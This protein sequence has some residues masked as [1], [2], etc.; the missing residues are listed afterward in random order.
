MS[1]DRE[2]FRLLGRS[3]E[4]F[5]DFGEQI[6]VGDGVEGDGLGEPGFVRQ[7]AF[8]DVKAFANVADEFFRLC[9]GGI[10]DFEFAAQRGRLDESMLAFEGVDLVLEQ[11]FLRPHLIQPIACCGQRSLTGFEEALPASEVF[12]PVLGHLVGPLV[13]ERIP[14][15]EGI[16]PTATDDQLKAFGAAA[17]SSGAVALFHAVGVTPEAATREQAFAGGEPEETRDVSPAD[18]RAARD[19]LST[20]AEGEP[21]DL[22]VLGC[23]HFS[24]AEFRHLAECIAAESGRAAHE[25]VAFLVITGQASHSL[26]QRAS[27][28]KE[29]DAF[30]VRITLDTCIFHT[31][32]LRPDTKVIMTNSGKCAYYAPGELS[33]RVAFGSTADCVR[34]AVA[35]R[36]SRS[37]T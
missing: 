21:L 11:C 26:L 37:E 34:S 1:S 8:R 15:I 7:D 24:Y 5:I 18:W 32:M 33:V 10:I 13:G 6:R 12:Y 4:V 22:V 35:G 27:W 9:D 29:L 25:N 16:P 2:F 3:G 31:P 28:R 19:D 20:A 30:G 23:P 14:V 17:A 36:V